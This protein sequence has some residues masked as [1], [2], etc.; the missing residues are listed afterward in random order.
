MSDPFSIGTSALLAFQR[1]MATASNNVANASTP[2]YTRQRV[3]FSTRIGQGQGFGFLGAGV[4]ISGV[5]R[6]LNSFLVSRMDAS[7]SELGRLQVLSGLATR[8]DRLVSEAGTSLPRPISDFF[9]STQGVATEP[10][11]SAARQSMLDGGENAAARFRTQANQLNQLDLETGQRIGN[12]VTEVNSLTAQIARLNREIVRAR[13]EFNQP[14]N[15]LL[16][17]RDQAV[18]ELSAK[19]GVITFEQD[20][21]AMNVQTSS[22]ASLV[23]GNNAQTISVTRDPFRLDRQQL[24]IT[25]PLGVTSLPTAGLGGELAGLYNFRSQVIDP[26]LASLGRT[27]VGLTETFNAQQRAGVDFNG[28]LGTDFFR[29]IAPSVLPSIN[30]GGTANFSAGISDVGA[31]T[32]RDIVLRWDG[33]N[34]QA[35][36]ASTGA[37]LPMTGTGT[38]ADPFI[39]EG[40]RLEVSGAPAVGDDIMVRTGSDAA[41]QMAMAMTD[42][43]RIAAALPVRASA[44]LGNQGTGILGPLSIADSANPNLQDPVTIEFTAAGVYS[45]NGAGAFAYTPGDKISVNGWEVT[46]DGTPAAGDQFNFSAM[47]A[48]SGDNGN[49]RLLTEVEGLGIF[50]GGNQNLTA[51]LSEMT[52]QFGGIARQ[53]EYTLGAQQSIDTQLQTERD[54]VSGVNLDEEAAN[55]LKFQQSY[56]AAAQIISIANAAFDSLLAAVRR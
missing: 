17:A 30:N 25:S 26:A 13:G 55:L 23:L 47:G 49:A 44:A 41:R 37:S 31:M 43:N 38:V 3:E 50:S 45:I 32:G 54:A 52:S 40:V 21:G 6:M 20:D 24:T 46:L 33:A 34:W 22:G 35:R 18:R 8:V 28:N 14:P 4:Q 48:R 27:A 15:D 29:P 39:V 10:T 53:A 11:S 19:I 2:G 51:A 1:A 9:D 56:Q 5:N 7:A 16:D 36:L 42:P 12:T